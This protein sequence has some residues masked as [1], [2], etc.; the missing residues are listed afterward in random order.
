MTNFKLEPFVTLNALSA[1]SGIVYINNQLYL[2]SDSSTFLYQYN[3][4]TKELIKIALETNSEE[5]ILKKDKPYRDFELGF[6]MRPL[7]PLLFRSNILL[8]F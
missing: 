8:H 1:A 7:Q 2:I 4:I 5:N 6:M 3:I